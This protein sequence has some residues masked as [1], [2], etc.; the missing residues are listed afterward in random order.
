MITNK[1]II[2]LSNEILDLLIDL[3][4]KLSFNFGLRVK[5]N[6]LKQGLWFQGTEHYVSIGLSSLG[7]GNL[8]TQSISLLIDTETKNFGLSLII[9]YP[10]NSP[11]D[12]KVIYEGIAK[13]LQMN[14][15]QKLYYKKYNFS[16]NILENIEFFF[17]NEYPI[18]HSIIVEKNGSKLLIDDQ[19]FERNLSRIQI[20]K[21]LIIND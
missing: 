20:E 18:L 21:S 17:E 14:S 6:R 11:E 5:G 10:A 12:L 3:R 9:E 15:N 7:A 19:K 16:D 2:Q 13:R 1:S 8:A 4:S